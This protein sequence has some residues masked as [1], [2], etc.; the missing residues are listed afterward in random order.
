MD[1]LKP[2]PFCGG[3]ATFEHLENGRWSV[4]CADMDGECMG[5]QSLQTFPRKADALK[6]WDKRVPTNA[7]HAFQAGFDA[8][9]N[10]ARGHSTKDHMAAWASYTPIHPDNE[11]LH[12]AEKG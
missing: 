7:E 12:E 1:E 11:R 6:A 10:G 9:F 2:C 8:G 4:G 3:G 5:F